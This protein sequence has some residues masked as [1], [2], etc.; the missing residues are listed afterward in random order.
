MEGLGA[1]AQGFNSV[2]SPSLA[3][4]PIVGFQAQTSKRRLDIEEME[5]KRKGLEHT[6]NMELLAK[7]L[8]HEG[9]KLK[10]LPQ[11]PA[12]QEAYRKAELDAKLAGTRRTI[13]EAGTAEGALAAQL[14]PEE[15]KGFTRRRLEADITGAG[16]AEKFT[17]AQIDAM[18][19]KMAGDLDP[20]EIKAIA[21]DNARLDKLMKEQGMEMGELQI[22]ELRD[23]IAS[24][25]PPG[26]LRE[27]ARRRLGAEIA[28]AETAIKLTK[29]QIEIAK[30]KRLSEL[31]P[32]ELRYFARRSMMA[33]IKGKETGT[34]LTEE[35]IET[36][37]K[38]RESMLEPARAKELAEQGLVSGI[39]REK[40]TTAKLEADLASMPEP[41]LAKKLMTRSMEAR[42]KG[43]E[44]QADVL[45][46]QAK[47]ETERAKELMRQGSPDEIDRRRRLAD[48][49]EQNKKAQT[50]V[51]RLQGQGIAIE[52]TLAQ[53]KLLELFQGV[54]PELAKTILDKGADSLDGYRGIYFEMHKRLPTEEEEAEYLDTYRTSMLSLASVGKNNM[55]DPAIRTLY[56]D[57]ASNLMEGISTG[58]MSKAESYK[59]A[60][61]KAAM[62]AQ[63]KTRGPASRPERAYK[64]PKLTPKWADVAM[65]AGI[66][67]TPETTD[68][69]LVYDPEFREEMTKTTGQKF[70][71]HE[72]GEVYILPENTGDKVFQRFGEL[73]DEWLSDD[74]YGDEYSEWLRRN[75]LTPSPKSIAQYKHDVL[76]EARKSFNA[77]QGVDA[78]ISPTGGGGYLHDAIFKL[79]GKGRN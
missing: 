18:R 37:K 13:A 34:K 49:D 48:L 73:F 32:H 79:A 78:S 75:N 36:A 28:G 71:R 62:L 45:E 10:L 35:Q 9:I 50:A 8:E 52:N 14:P 41:A 24:Q 70:Y 2:A 54:D 43:D 53:K 72:G 4:A 26:E 11:T 44:G 74:R 7:Q 40:A 3:Q 21:R 51:T 5:S 30:H 68:A 17:Q 61:F 27:Y 59:N 38:Q 42:A 66:P 76:V 39:A 15:I 57:W 6:K 22:E 55:N 56:E 19:Q 77:R 23:K 29:E 60:L 64:P 16:T 20:E 46:Q 31:E 58:D 1:L 33:D 63:E 12:E 47:Q 65:R 67:V 25:V 69:D